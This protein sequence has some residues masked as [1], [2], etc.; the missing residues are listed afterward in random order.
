MLT[1]KW[2]YWYFPNITGIGIFVSSRFS[3]TVFFFSWYSFSIKTPRVIWYY[4]FCFNCVCIDSLSQICEYVLRLRSSGSHEKLRHQ[5]L[6]TPAAAAK[7][8]V[9]CVLTESVK[10]KKVKAHKLFMFG[11]YV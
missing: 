5:P 4:A 11:E 6:T 7:C 10:N 9:D 8:N 2:L 1:F 3:Y